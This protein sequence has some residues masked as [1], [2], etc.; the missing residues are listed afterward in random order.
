MMYNT[1]VMDVYGN[2]VYE[3]IPSVYILDS[4][5]M[6]QDIDMADEKNVI[7]MTNMD[8]ARNAKTNADI[9]KKIVP[10]LGKANVLLFVINHI[11]NKIEANPFSHSQSQNNYLK[12]GESIVGG[13]TPQWGVFDSDIIKI[14]LFNC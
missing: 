2:P 5:P 6:L 13:N 12:Q 8:G 14:K 9:F 4:L 1:G 3:I 10:L 7:G 11:N